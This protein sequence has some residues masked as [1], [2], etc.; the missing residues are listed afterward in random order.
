M[1]EGRASKRAALI[2]PLDEVECP[3]AVVATPKA[4]DP[5]SARPK[6]ERPRLA[7]CRRQLKIDRL[8]VKLDDA[9][10]NVC[11]PVLRAKIE[12]LDNGRE[13]LNLYGLYAGGRTDSG[14]QGEQDT[15]AMRPLRQIRRS[16]THRD[17]GSL[18]VEVAE[19]HAPLASAKSAP[20]TRLPSAHRQGRRLFEHPHELLMQY[21]V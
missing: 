18:D 19:Y 7:A 5:V 4:D 8:P 13:V 6:R 11:S 10:P 16:K 1:S 14:Q 17:Q 3:F 2:G 12:E 9:E 21:P 15:A 20:H